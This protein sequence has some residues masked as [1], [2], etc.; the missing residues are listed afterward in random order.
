MFRVRYDNQGRGLTL[1]PLNVLQRDLGV[2][3]VASQGHL[4]LFVDAAN[5]ALLQRALG[6]L[7]LARLSRAASFDPQAR[8]GAPVRLLFDEMPPDRAHRLALA[9]GRGAVRLAWREGLLRCEVLAGPERIGRALAEV[10][11]EAQALTGWR[12]IR[13]H[14]DK[15]IPLPPGRIALPDA[16]AYPTLASRNT[17]LPVFGP[18]EDSA[19]CGDSAPPTRDSAPCGDSVPWR[20]DSDALLPS[21]LPLGRQEA[22]GRPVH[23]P[24]PLR[25]LW[26]GVTPPAPSVLRRVTAA[27][28]GLQPRGDGGQPRE[29]GAESRDDGV[30]PHGDGQ[31]VIV[32]DGVGWSARWEADFTVS[33]VHPGQGGRINPLEPIGASSRYGVRDAAAY[34]D[35]V[36]EWLTVLGINETLIGTPVYRLLRV[37]L[38]IW[39]HRSLA[40]ADEPLSPPLIARLLAQPRLTEDL[41]IPPLDDVEDR[42]IWVTRNWT[43]AR[44]NLMPAAERLRS[45]LERPQLSVLWSP[46]FTPLSPSPPHPC[47]PLLSLLAPGGGRATRAFLASSWL[48]LRHR[49]SPSTL[50]VGLGIGELGGRVLADAEAKGASVLLWG[51]R[52][53]DACGEVQ[54]YATGAQSRVDGAQSRVDGAQSRVDGAVD[55]DGVDLLVSRTPDAPVLARQVGVPCEHLLAQADDQLVA[56]FGGRVAA[57]VLPDAPHAAHEA[58]KAQ[59]TPFSGP[60]IVLGPVERAYVFFQA[61][62]ACRRQAGESPLLLSGNGNAPAPPDVP[63]RPLPPLNPLHPRSLPRWLWWARATGLGEATARRAWDAG[64][65]C[66]DDLLPLVEGTPDARR[67]AR[68]VQSGHFEGGGGAPMTAWN[69]AA[70]VLTC[71]EPA[72]TCAFVAATLEAGRQVLLWQPGVALSPAVLRRLRAVVY[73]PVGE[74]GDL[75]LLILGDGPGVPER[76]REQAQALGEGEG[77]LVG[78]GKG[79]DPRRREVQRVR[80][81]G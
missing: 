81:Y 41:P 10:W 43:S 42:T 11:P 15:G 51:E 17:H 9:L 80:L 4:I 66:L 7:P 34:A 54:P 61:L 23:L 49:L 77:L 35:L 78:P 63:R 22:N 58:P 70:A 8:L 71:E 56:R 31:N 48:P 55:L 60:L 25:A 67:V 30:Q 19:P 36:L 20:R 1:A 21:G 32:L 57:L 13:G 53:A 24:V 46:P 3:W 6:D 69:G 52:I 2:L 44:A 79:R 65:G 64:A 27:W 28:S 38:K 29:D 40:L 26:I 73:A 59:R 33:W 16:R 37:T 47:P 5:E 68:W 12:R 45:L 72:A 50:V 18:C 74:S 62:V 75:P 76:L 39:A 14:L